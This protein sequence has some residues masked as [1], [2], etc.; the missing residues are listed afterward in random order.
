M[1]K[2][3]R[4]NP[5]GMFYTFPRHPLMPNFPA[6]QGGGGGGPIYLPTLAVAPVAVYGVVKLVSGYS[7]PLLCVCATADSDTP[8]STI[9]VYP[10]ANGRADFSAALAAFGSSFDVYRVYDQTGSGNHATASAATRRAKILVSHAWSDAGLGFSFTTVSQGFVIPDTLATSRQSVSIFS[11]T[12]QRGMQ[13]SNTIFGLNN[14]GS[15]STYLNLLSDSRIQALGNSFQ[16]STRAGT[17]RPCVKS[18]RSGVS[19]VKVGR[20]DDMTTLTAMSAS[21]SMAGGAIGGIKN[22]AGS[23][24][25][26]YRSCFEDHF[27]HIVYPAQ[28]TDGDA[29]TLNSALYSIFSIEHAYNAQLVFLGDSIMYGQGSTD[30]VGFPSRV[31][32]Y[33]TSKIVAVSNIST[34]GTSLGTFAGAPSFIVSIADMTASRRVLYVQRGTNDIGGSATLSTMQ[35]YVSSV[36]SALGSSYEIVF[37]T[38]L[39]RNSGWNGTRE[40]IRNDYNAWL[41]DPATQASL[42]IAV[43]DRTA[44]GT[45]GNDPND[46]S[47]Y[48]DLLHPTN[49]LYQELADHEGPLLN[50]MFP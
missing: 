7:G 13:S 42:D 1:A 19:N 44:G 5:G 41:L 18:L 26:T 49:L 47:R 22:G 17:L 15:T 20:N 48:G 2:S 31:L 43:I 35:G 34:P 29:A 21:A 6:S 39:P 16:Y 33:L 11:V 30:G 4:S 28:I 12:A 9:D 40:T 23:L 32:P 3:G 45:V 24:A 37:G 10:G 38:I 36:V 46:T 8:G 27:A 50:A 14:T 25:A